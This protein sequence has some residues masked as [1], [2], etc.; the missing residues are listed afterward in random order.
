MPT[1]QDLFS[2]EQTMVTMSFGDHIEELRT[3]LVLALLGLAVTVA[4]T[5]IPNIPLGGRRVIPL[6][7]GGR[8]LRRMQDPAQVALTYF[9]E[10]QAKRRAQEA[11]ENNETTPP[12]DGEVELTQLA[13]AL[14]MIAPELKT[15]PLE[16]LEGRKVPLKVAYRRANV[17]KLIQANS[18]PVN[19]LVALAPLEGFMIYFMV[20]TVAGLVLASPWVFYQLWAFIAAGLYRHERRY[21]LKFLPFSL[22]LFLGG[23]FLC[24]FLVLPWTLQFLLEFN[25]KLGIEPTLRISEWMSF[26]TILPLVFGVCFQ[27]PLVML[28]L[29]RIGIM[30]AQDFREKRRMAIFVVFIAAA[31]ITPTSDPFTLMLLAGP[32]ILLYELGLVLIGRQSVAARPTPV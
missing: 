3:R 14:R 31:I 19:A 7:I 8:V 30:S 25:V 20:C 17:I 29:E 32:M 4:V 2:E 27:T 12:L 13:S 16:R 1:D 15:I 22:V 18:R 9:Y 6:D 11:D 5:F 24:F 21:V 23:V 28:V 26:A 10:E